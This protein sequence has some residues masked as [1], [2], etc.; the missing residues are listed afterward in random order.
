VSGCEDMYV[1]RKLDRCATGSAMVDGST[2][3]REAIR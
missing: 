2:V 3:G 1:Q